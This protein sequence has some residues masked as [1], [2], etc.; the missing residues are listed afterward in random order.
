MIAEDVLFSTAV[1]AGWTKTSAYAPIA[2]VPLKAGLA[3]QF[4][5]SAGPSTESRML[6]EVDTVISQFQAI[7]NR[8]AKIDLTQDKKVLAAVTQEADAA[9]YSTPK[10]GSRSP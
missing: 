3:D 9:S 2:C 10:V 8:L 7:K 1:G 6:A 5:R 4:R